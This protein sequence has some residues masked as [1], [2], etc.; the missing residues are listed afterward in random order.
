M[1]APLETLRKKQLMDGIVYT[2]G[3]VCRY[4]IP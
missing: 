4:T 2:A 1:H 3:I